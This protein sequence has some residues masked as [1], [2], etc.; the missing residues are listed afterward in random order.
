M[1]TADDQTPVELHL[2]AG[3]NA[4]GPEGRISINALSADFQGCDLLMD[5]A[6]EGDETRFLAKQKGFHPTV[7]PKSNRL[8]P[9]K[10][11]KRKYKGRNVV[12]RFF[13]RIKQFRRI[14][15]RYDKLD[16]IY[17]S[18]VQLTLIFIW[19]K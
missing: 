6:Y 2:S 14:N 11:N 5:R 9:W 12:E 16:M 7:P 19:I 8:Y 17:M 13:R 4:D 15:T 18:F 3:N 1:V 10:Y